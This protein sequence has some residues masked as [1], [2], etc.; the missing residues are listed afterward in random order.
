MIE[1]NI[2][3]QLIEFVKSNNGIDSFDRLDVAL[4]A[5][6][7]G[8][9]D[10]QQVNNLQDQYRNIRYKYD[11]SY[12]GYNSIDRGNDVKDYQTVFNGLGFNQSLIQPKM[13]NFSQRK[14]GATGDW[15]NTFT[16]DGYY[17]G[18]TNE[19]YIVPSM[20]PWEH[21]EQ[22]WQLQTMTNQAGYD[23]YMDTN[24]EG[25]VGKLKP[26]GTQLWQSTNTQKDQTGSPSVVEGRGMPKKFDYAGL[27]NK[28]G[29]GIQGNLGN[30]IEGARYIRSIQNN[31]KV[32]YSYWLIIISICNNAFFNFVFKVF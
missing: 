9:L 24:P 7:S 28:I 29:A 17:Q 11:P 12:S 13:S 8:K 3:A 20:K 26:L 32:F 25:T 31:N 4:K 5:L 16:P 1:E 27:F 30:I 15:N 22:Y 23:Y 19:R 14:K 6:R 2:K 18:L 10:Y 21:P